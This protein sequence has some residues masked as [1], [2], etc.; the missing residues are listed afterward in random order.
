MFAD[1]KV[2]HAKSYSS[3][4]AVSACTTGWRVS[5]DKSKCLANVCVCH[6]GVASSGEKCATDGDN[7]CDSCDKGSKLRQ[8]KT[9]C[10]GRLGG[11]GKIGYGEGFVYLCLLILCLFRFDTLLVGIWVLCVLAFVRGHLFE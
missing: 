8:D 7:M 2:Q 4:C 3:G 9:A 11:R 1:C 10:D 6:N 5:G